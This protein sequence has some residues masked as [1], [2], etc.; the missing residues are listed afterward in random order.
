MV[1]MAMPVRYEIVPNMKRG[2]TPDSLSSLLR[3]EGVRYDAAAVREK[4]E[5]TELKSVL[6]KAIGMPFAGGIS[7]CERKAIP[8]ICLMAVPAAMP[9]MTSGLRGRPNATTAAEFEGMV[10]MD[11]RFSRGSAMPLARMPY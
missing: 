4:I 5:F 10:E 3:I 11:R 9:R 2:E 1:S 8:Y 6:K 7:S